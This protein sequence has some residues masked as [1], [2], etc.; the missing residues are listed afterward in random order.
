MASGK[1]PGA[2]FLGACSRPLSRHRTASPSVAA[3]RR[4]RF[5]YQRRRDP[6]VLHKSSF[7]HPESGSGCQSS[8]RTRSSGSRD[9]SKGAIRSRSDDP[10]AGIPLA[11]RCRHQLEQK[12]CPRRLG[13]NSPPQCRH[14]VT[15]APGARVFFART[16]SAVSTAGGSRLAPPP[17]ARELRGRCRRRTWRPQRALRRST[18]AIRRYFAELHPEV[19]FNPPSAAWLPAKT[20]IGAVTER[21]RPG[22]VATRLTVRPYGSGSEIREFGDSVLVL[23]H[24]D[25]TARTAGI[26]I[27]QEVGSS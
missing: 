8:S 9:G 23:G 13:W 12:T 1:V 3:A 27:S 22:S 10:D 16:Q 7:T 20:P 18:A 26:E 6:T 2:T 5:R 19:E 24:I 11:P 14:S 4:S 17:T 15:R 25:L 21:E